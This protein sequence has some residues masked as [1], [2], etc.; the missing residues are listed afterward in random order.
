M[1]EAVEPH[2]RPRRELEVEPARHGE[3]RLARRLEQ[4]V[5][6]E[7]DG[8]AG[9]RL[10]ADGLGE[11]RR[12][13]RAADPVREGV[14]PAQRPP[15]RD[16]ARE[17]LVGELPGLTGLALRDERVQP[18]EVRERM[19]LEPL[20]GEPA[21]DDPVGGDDVGL[22]VGDP[23]RPQVVDVL[24]ELREERERARRDVRMPARRDLPE[25]GGER[26]PAQ[27]RQDALAAASEVDVGAVAA[28]LRRL[29][30]AGLVRVQD[31]APGEHSR[32]VR[33][34]RGDEREAERDGSGDGERGGKTLEASRGLPARHVPARAEESGVAV[35][36]VT[37][38]C[39]EA[40]A[41]FGS[42]A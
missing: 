3:V 19:E 41:D 35:I 10:G 33:P 28:P 27:L 34:R 12:P 16:R 6:A 9:E 38:R 1:V 24:A 21:V 22:V 39:F 25:L 14:L 2:P 23:V 26:L 8:G 5:V 40:E 11:A 32:L 13:R 18:R 36:R 29:D 7:Q 30:P 37:A 42:T 17:Q 4:R 31:P 15:V 20:A